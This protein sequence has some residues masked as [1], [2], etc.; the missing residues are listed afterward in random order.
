VVIDDD[1]LRKCPGIDKL[2]ADTRDKLKTYLQEQ[3]KIK[4]K[5]K[6]RNK[7]KYFPLDLVVKSTFKRYMES[8]KSRQI[9]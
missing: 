4:E 9:C 3:V 2:R 8:T 6:R 5:K 1:L 7:V